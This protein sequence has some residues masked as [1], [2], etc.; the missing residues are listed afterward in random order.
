MKFLWI[1]LY[2]YSTKSMRKVLNECKKYIY[3]KKS[4][5]WKIWRKKIFFLHKMLAYIVNNI[6]KA[7]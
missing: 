3:F 7:L 5:S 2:E 1:K 6:L 4:I